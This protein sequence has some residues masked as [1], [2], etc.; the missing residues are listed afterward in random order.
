MKHGLAWRAAVLFAALSMPV[1]SW[2]S[3]RGAFG[4]DNATLSARYPTLLIAAGYAFAIWGPIFLLDVAMAAWHLGQPRAL[5]AVRRPAALAFALT[6]TWMIVFPLQRFWVSLLVIVGSLGALLVAALR[7]STPATRGER[8]LLWLPLSLQAGWVSLA[9]FL[10]L[11]QVIVAYRLLPTTAM[12]DW[13]LVLFGGCAALLLWANA[14]LRGNVVY[15]AAIVWGLAGVYVAQSRSS[16]QGAPIAAWTAVGLGV[17][18][19]LQTAWLRTRSRGG[20]TD[21]R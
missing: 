12:L 11:A 8:L 20:V 1:V 10:N 9:A 13:S 15:V 16:L 21:G 3:Q 14:R 4:P 19:V 7:A 5:D 6:S 17:A 2:L 18:V